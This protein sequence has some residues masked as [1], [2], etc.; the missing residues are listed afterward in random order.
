VP[1]AQPYEAAIAYGAGEKPGEVGS[2]WM[3]TFGGLYQPSLGLGAVTG[4]GFMLDYRFPDA[5]YANRFVRSEKA[6]R[7]TIVE[8]APGK[9]EKLFAEYRFTPAACRGMKFDF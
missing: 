2:F 4:D 1:P 7:W 6:W 5:V 8:Q 9:P 3:D